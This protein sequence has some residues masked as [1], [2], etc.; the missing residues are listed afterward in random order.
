ML[1]C[2]RSPRG[3]ARPWISYKMSRARDLPP[4]SRFPSTVFMLIGSR[5]Q[6]VFRTLSSNLAPQVLRGG[7][8]AD[9]LPHGDPDIRRVPVVHTVINARIRNFADKVVDP[10]PT[11]NRTRCR[12]A[13]GAQLRHRS[14]TDLALENRADGRRMNAVSA[15]IF[16][17]HRRIDKRRPRSISLGRVVA[18]DVTVPNSCDRPPKV[19]VVLRVEYRDQ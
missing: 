12:G 7:Q 14:R 11:T 2:W 8:R 17:V 15:R 6:R 1:C 10:C 3:G 16:R 18:V 5:G 13:G 19:V 4:D 9:L